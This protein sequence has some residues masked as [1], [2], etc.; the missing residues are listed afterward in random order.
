MLSCIFLYP[1]CEIKKPAQ[2]SG[3]F[4]DMPH[5]RKWLTVAHPLNEEETRLPLLFLRV[6]PEHW[7]LEA[8]AQAMDWEHED[9]L[10]A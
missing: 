9:L 1:I 5:F 7:E 10:I 8:I 6:L 4:L 2:T 3:Y